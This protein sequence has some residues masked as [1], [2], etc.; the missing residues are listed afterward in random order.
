MSNKENDLTTGE[1]VLISAVRTAIGKFGRSLKNIHAQRLGAA[2]IKESVNRAGIQPHQV[3]EVIMGNAISAGL[4]QNPA[5]QSAI[6]AGLPYEIGSFTINKVCGSGLKAVILAAQA[7]KADDAEIVVAGGMENM[8]SAPHLV[9]NIRWGLK[10]GDLKM[11]DAMLHD[12]LWD[13]YND[14]LMGATGERVAG[15]YGITRNEA[16]EFSLQSQQKALRAIR[17]GMFKDEIIP[18]EVQG[19]I[20]EEDECIR[21]DTTLEK[22]SKLTTAFKK[23]GILT[24]GNSSKLSDGAAAL[25]I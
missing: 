8:S 23:D 16:D 17:E 18:V 25:V 3:D 15:K 19:R 2:V 4:G 24:A 13:V 11:I 7:I 5:R 6:Y 12:G 20:F 21:A 22:L 10:F 14:Y 9:R 1:V